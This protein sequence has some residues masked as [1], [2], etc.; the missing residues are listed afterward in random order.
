VRAS[1]PGL[2]RSPERTKAIGLP[3]HCVSDPLR[4]VGKRWETVLPEEQDKVK[5][6][7]IGPFAVQVLAGR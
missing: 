4:P 7:G 1:P 3:R 5:S 6:S 2:L